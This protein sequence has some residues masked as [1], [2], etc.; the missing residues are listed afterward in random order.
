[1]YCSTCGSRVPEGRRACDTCGSDMG[2]TGRIAARMQSA[3]FPS[4]ATSGAVVIGSCPRC[5]FRGEG[6]P[7][8]SRGKHVVALVGFAMF[9]AGIMGAGGLGYYLVRRDHQV[10]PRC[11]RTW[12]RQGERALVRSTAPEMS[13]IPTAALAAP[14]SPKRLWSFLLFALAALLAVAGILATEVGPL[15][16]AGLAAAGGLVAQRAAE[17]DRERRRA[18]LLTTLQLPVLQLA[19]RRGGTLTV[20]EVAA[21]LGW[22]MRRAEKVLQSLDDGVRVSSEVTDE[23][24]IVY[25]FRELQRPSP[26]RLYGTQG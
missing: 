20:T 12:G 13:A 4:A 8:F 10:C 18:A 2:R 15:V 11:G 24:L 25:E 22:P 23:G 21:E 9:T 17:S 3:D 6:L 26:G 16:A 5:S 19:S 7:Y 1:M 14:E